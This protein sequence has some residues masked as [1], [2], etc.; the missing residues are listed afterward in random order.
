M[1]ELRERLRA[2]ETVAPPDLWSEIDRR[3]RGDDADHVVPLDRRR[4]R[5]W[6]PRLAA[7][8]V[9]ALVALLAGVLV[10]RAFRPA[11]PTQPAELP[12]GWVRCTNDV[13]GYSIGHPGAWFTTDIL[14]GERDPAYACRW[15]SREPF[16]LVDDRGRP[17]GN[18]VTEGDGYPLEVGI[19]GAFDQE[20]QIR[21]D[22]ERADVSVQRELTIEGRRAVLLEYVTLIDL[23]QD[24]GRH[25]EYL[26]ELDEERTLIVHTTDVRGISGPDGRLYDEH[27][28]IVDQAVE[29]L[30]FADPLP[31]AL[32]A[33]W[34]RCTNVQRG[35][36][37][38][39]PADWFT[40]DVF[41]G[42]RR[43]G[44]ACTIFA[45]VSFDLQTDAGEPFGMAVE[46]GCGYPVCVRFVPM[47]LDDLLLELSDPQRIEVVTSE[48]LV[49]GGRRAARLDRIVLESGLGE[50]AGPSYHYLIELDAGRT[51]L[52]TTEGRDNE[53]GDATGRTQVVLRAEDFEANK[54]VLDQMV[55]TLRI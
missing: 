43:P 29:T 19:G 28:R 8:A 3:A 1:P 47:P 46:E 7:V 51:L 11:P 22:P 55:Q 49:V 9:A 12:A 40:T 15:F 42:D 37:I 14:I 36:D 33:E 16:D 4:R 27:T 10:W 53:V 50:P 30:R 34:Q 32:R 35:F 23:I 45:S 2:I 54:A 25:Y 39:Y 48:E 31:G 24:L 6:G 21:T 38:G 17:Q 44:E 13:E 18:V 52:F 20:L 26:I 5:S 41:F